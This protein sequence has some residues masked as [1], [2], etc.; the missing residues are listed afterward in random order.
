MLLNAYDFSEKREKVGY[1]LHLEDK[2]KD[3]RNIREYYSKFLKEYKDVT[4]EYEDISF[5]Q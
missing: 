1:F 2:V 4:E 3:V 5:S